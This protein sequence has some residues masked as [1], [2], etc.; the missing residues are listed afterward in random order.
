MQLISLGY[1]KDEN[2]NIYKVTTQCLAPGMYSE[3]CEYL[4]TALPLSIIPFV[5]FFIS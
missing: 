5:P 3:Y 1:Y 2:D 4:N